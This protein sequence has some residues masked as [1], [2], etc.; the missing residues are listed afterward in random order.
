MR[1][2]ITIACVLILTLIVSGIGGSHAMAQNSGCF[3]ETGFCISGRFQQFWEQHGGL[4]VFGYPLGAPFEQDG[5][6]VQYFERQRFELHPEN[7]PPYD[8]LLGRLGDDALRQ[9]ST[10]WHSLPQFNPGSGTADCMYFAQTGHAACGAFRSYWMSHGLEFDGRSGKSYA[11]SLALFG[12][13]LSEPLQ[14]TASNGETVQAQWFER[15]R[16]EWHPTNPD[17]YKVLLGRLGAEL[18]P[19]TPPSTADLAPAVQTVLD[20]YDAINQRAFDR[21]YQLWAGN[22]AASGQTFAQFQQG[23]TSTVRVD[24]LLGT[25]E[26]PNAGGNVSVPVGV[27]AVVNDSSSPIGQRVQQFRGTYSVAPGTT[28]WQLA[29]ASVAQVTGELPPVALREPDVLVRS[30]Y[31]A[32]SRGDI[33]SAYT[34]WEDFGRASGQT[35]AQFAQGYANTDHVTVTLGQIQSDAGAGN[36]YATVPVVIVATQRDGAQRAFCGT[37]T[38]HRANI[39]PFDLLGW[40]ISRAAIAPTTK[41][42]PA[43]DQANGC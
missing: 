19:A 41:I 4:A 28:G 17:P 35:F 20:Y 30:Y 21:A 40:H 32:I 14:Y 1:R 16:F 39:P 22:G 13:P 27:F 34:F 38:L 8:V 10:D 2:R 18:L 36:L 15:A 37:Y 29:S 43:S 42:P 5:R 12:Y 23:F 7:Q 9:S 31:E 11:E 25:P 33:A 3:P 26:R 6:T 24:V